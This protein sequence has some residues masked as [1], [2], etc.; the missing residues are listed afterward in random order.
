MLLIEGTSETRLL[1]HLSNHV[2]GVPKFKNTS[3][4]CS[5]LNLNVENA[6]KKLKNHKLFLV[7]EIIPSENVAINCLY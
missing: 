4:M 3:A 1:R 6:K 7:S 2:F 5:K